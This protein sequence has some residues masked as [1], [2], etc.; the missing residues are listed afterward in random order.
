MEV[1]N[2]INSLRFLFLSII[3]MAENT[4]RLYV[5]NGTIK[6]FQ[7][8]NAVINISIDLAQVAQHAK[9]GKGRYLNLVVSKIPEDKRQYDQTHTIYQ[10]DW[11]L[12]NREDIDLKALKDFET[13]GINGGGN[14]GKPVS[15][16][17]EDELFS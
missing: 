14:S 7:D 3:I 12:T 4:Q 10:D 8:G 6:K 17:D 1:S 9:V 16:E 5:G 2:H 11:N 13:K 15:K